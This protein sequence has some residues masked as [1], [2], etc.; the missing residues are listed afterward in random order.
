MILLS[1]MPLFMLVFL[2]PGGGNA[3]PALGA[4]WMA[5]R[6]AV[7]ALG[8]APLALARCASPRPR[9]ASTAPGVESLRRAS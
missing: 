6:G 4:L 9:E 7:F 2:I 5:H 1:P 3:Y 8:S